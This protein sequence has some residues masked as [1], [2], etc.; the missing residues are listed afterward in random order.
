MSPQKTVS[1][2]KRIVNIINGNIGGLQ[3]KF[4]LRTLLSFLISL[5]LPYLSSN[6]SVG[7][8]HELGQSVSDCIVCTSSSQSI[9]SLSYEI[10]YVSVSLVAS[11][12]SVNQSCSSVVL[13]GIT[14][15]NCNECALEGR[16]SGVVV[17]EVSANEVNVVVELSLVV[18]SGVTN[19]N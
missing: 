1:A 18:C 13:S 17:V 15:N 12:S 9:L 11:S 8:S 3:I 16:T 19:G 4:Q 6:V 14:V 7:S 2:R 10:S 5:V